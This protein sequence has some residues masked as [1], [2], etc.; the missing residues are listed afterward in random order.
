ML[1][2]LGHVENTLL[3]LDEALLLLDFLVDDL[4]DLLVVLRVTLRLL[5]QAESELG[6]SDL[7]VDRDRSAVDVFAVHL[8]RALD[9]VRA[10][11]VNVAEPGRMRRE[12]IIKL[13]AYKV[14]CTGS[15]PPL[16]YVEAH[17]KLGRRS[18]MLHRHAL[19]SELSILPFEVL[20][21]GVVD[22]ADVLDF[23]VLL[24]DLT[25]LVLLHVVG[26]VLHEDSLAVLRNVLG[27]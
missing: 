24:E 26:Q 3:V 18:K 8:D 10:L 14:P 6:R 2:F 15:A 16:A 1:L 12:G 19:P 7:E 13:Q 11:E 17:N 27:F 22:E 21:E 9:A 25:E 5:V 4:L 20:V 23:A